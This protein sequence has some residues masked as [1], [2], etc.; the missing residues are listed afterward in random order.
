MAEELRPDDPES[1]GPYRLVNRLGQGGMGTVYLGESA[2]GQQVAIKVIN[3]ELTGSTQFLDR[4]R[5]EVAAARRVRRFCTAPVLDASL[6]EAPLYVVTE[7]IAGPTLQ[8]VVAESG[9]MRGSDLEGLAVGVATALSAIHDASLVHRDLKPSNVLLSPVG[10]RVIDFGIARALD[11][12]TGVTRTGQ[13]IGTPAFLAPE[14]VTGGEVTFASDVFSWGCVVVFAGVGRGPF[15][16]STIPEI[17]HRVAYDPP[18]LDGLDPSLRAL[19]EGALHKSPADRP[20]VPEMLEQLTGRRSPQPSAEASRPQAPPTQAVHPGPPTLPAHPGPPAQAGPPTLP[21]HQIQPPPPG[22]PPR[23]TPPRRTQPYEMSPPIP[24]RH[25]APAYRPTWTNPPAPQRRRRSGCVIGF[26]LVALAVAVFLV[27]V[28]AAAIGSRN[29]GLDG[30]SAEASGDPSH[31]TSDVG[32]GFLGTWRGSINQSGDPKS[33]YPAILTMKSGQVHDVIG[34]S[35]YPTL[36]CSGRLTLLKSSKSRLTVREDITEGT[37]CVSATI[38]L[39]HRSN[40]S[41]DYSFSSPSPGHG[42]LKKK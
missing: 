10:L 20:T 21:A 25:N 23:S 42:T 26:L 13:I 39:V 2:D 29:R 41:L 28:L 9:P 16:G 3:P 15:E 5:R 7:F 35:S 27:V 34:H 24:P 14:L 36:K 38:T 40:G 1:F 11:A 30:G 12:Q 37:N 4:F 6:D 31:T 8:E 32:T 22:P 19:V 17:L 18:Q 33:P